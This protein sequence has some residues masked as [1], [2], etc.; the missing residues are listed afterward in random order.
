MLRHYENIKRA[1]RL[2]A[3]ALK[4]SAEAVEGTEFAILAGTG[5]PAGATYG[6]Q[7]LEAAQKAIALRT[8]APDLDSAF[9]L[10][11]NG[12]TLWTAGKFASSAW[13]TGTTTPA[14]DSVAG[15]HAAVAGTAANAFPGPFTAMDVDRTAKCV[16]GVGW[17]G[18]NVAITS[19]SPSESRRPRPSRVPERAAARSSASSPSRP[20]PR[21][22]P[23]RP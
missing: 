4:P 12:G 7:T 8:D 1:G 19:T 23:P 14:A 2:L 9:Y 16:F 6:E 15:V 21:S 20:A 13:Y 10:T 22:P 5:V 17:D 11:L 18:G 3:L